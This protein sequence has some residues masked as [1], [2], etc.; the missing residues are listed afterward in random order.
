MNGEKL[1]VWHFNVAALEN[2]LKALGLTRTHRVAGQFS[3]LQRRTS[4]MLRNL[5][6][7]F[8]NGYYRL[9]LPAGPAITNLLVFQKK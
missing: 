8:N 9:G 6:L 5:L 3:E 4:G 1:W 7:H 2:Y